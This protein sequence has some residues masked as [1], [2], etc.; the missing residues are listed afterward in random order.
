MYIWIVN[1]I[2]KKFWNRYRI[3]LT[4]YTFLISCRLL[5]GHTYQST[6]VYYC[7]AFYNTTSPEPFLPDARC[8]PSPK[9]V[10]TYE[11]DRTPQKSPVKRSQQLNVVSPPAKR[12]MKETNYSA[13]RTLALGWET[14]ASGDMKSGYV[15]LCV[16]VCVCM[17]VYVR[18]RRARVSLH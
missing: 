16:C 11:S 2:L 7:V 1:E 6:P 12:F 15:A 9:T 4:Y 3:V 14:G 8:R 18:A 17:Y 5:N 10:K 13:R